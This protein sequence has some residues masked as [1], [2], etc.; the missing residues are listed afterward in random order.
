LALL[1]S[2]VKSQASV[3]FEPHAFCLQLEQSYRQLLS[4]I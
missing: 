3:L 2:K 1:K 4:R